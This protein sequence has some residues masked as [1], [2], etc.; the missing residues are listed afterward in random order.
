MRF[1][2]ERIRESFLKKVCIGG[3]QGNIL[4]WS[5]RSTLE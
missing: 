3:E 4:V 5:P 2:R 1:A